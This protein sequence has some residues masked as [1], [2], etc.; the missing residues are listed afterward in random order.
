MIFNFKIILK[1]QT[2]ISNQTIKRKFGGTYTIKDAKKNAR[3]YSH[4]SR[5]IRSIKEQRIQYNR[6]SGIWDSWWDSN[7]EITRIKYYHTQSWQATRK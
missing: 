7:K 2:G 3:F 6:P 4:F 1:L 5:Q